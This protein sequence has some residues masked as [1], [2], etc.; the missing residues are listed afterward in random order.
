MTP[1]RPGNPI[2]SI[3]IPLV[4]GSVRHFGL[5][6]PGWSMLVVYRGRHC[7]R[8]KSYLRKLDGLLGAFAERRV[9]VV[10]TSADPKERAAADLAEHGW[11][12]ALGHSLS[13]ADMNALGLYV[14]DPVS[15]EETDRPFAEPGLFVV[16]PNGLIHVL[17]ISN[18]ASCRPDLD[19]VLDGIVGIQDKGLPIRGMRGIG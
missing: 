8:C 15:T 16:N 10:A 9:A 2:P 12:F 14:S 11:R 13:L 3:S 18:A 17:G 7:P 5:D 19:V 1:A 6:F 4:D